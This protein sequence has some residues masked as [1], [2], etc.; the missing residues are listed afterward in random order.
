MKRNLLST[1]LLFVIMISVAQSPQL[2]NYQ[3]VVRN[4]QGQTVANSTPIKLR[5][6]IH[7]VTPNGASVY[8]EVIND[9]VNQFGLANVQIGSGGNLGTINW[10][11]GAKFLQVEVNVGNTNYVEIGRAYV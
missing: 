8:S 6:T 2:M 10:G 5:F 11:N 1:L 3:E 9:T 7:D 4:A